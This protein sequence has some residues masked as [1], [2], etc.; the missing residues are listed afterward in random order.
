MAAFNMDVHQDFIRQLQM[1]DQYAGELASRIK[2]KVEQL[3]ALNQSIPAEQNQKRWPNRIKN[4]K[5]RSS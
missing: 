3:N 2:D 5:Q 4:P 1:F